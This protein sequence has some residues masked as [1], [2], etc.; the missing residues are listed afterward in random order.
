MKWS[1]HTVEGFSRYVCAMK[2]ISSSAWKN[3]DFY[4]QQN[5]D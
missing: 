1:N 3:R 2:V 4:Y 5:V